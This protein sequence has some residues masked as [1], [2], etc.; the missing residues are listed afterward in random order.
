MKSFTLNVFLFFLIFSQILLVKNNTNNDS[1]PTLKVVNKC[2]NCPKNNPMDFSS[3][4]SN[5][6]SGPALRKA[7]IVS[8]DIF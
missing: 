6:G 5:N 4:N 8:K 1:L 7:T 3:T 2:T